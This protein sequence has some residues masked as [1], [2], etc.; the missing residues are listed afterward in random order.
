MYCTK[1]YGFHQELTAKYPKEAQALYKTFK[2]LF[3]ALPLAAVIQGKTL[4]LHGDATLKVGSLEDLR[5]A[6]KGGQDPDGAL[7]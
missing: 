7:Q 1:Y 6:G 4:V 2:H 3:A 5:N